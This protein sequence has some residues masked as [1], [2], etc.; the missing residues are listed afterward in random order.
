[1]ILSISMKCTPIFRTS[2]RFIR[3]FHLSK[4][5]K[6]GNSTA[7][8]KTEKVLGIPLIVYQNSGYEHQRKS[9]SDA[10]EVGIN[11]DT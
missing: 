7:K 1:M 3:E 11:S 9:T 2:F 6:S 5:S 8:M 10:V 4:N